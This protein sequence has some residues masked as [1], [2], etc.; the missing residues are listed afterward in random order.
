VAAP[1]TDLLRKKV[2]WKWGELQEKAFQE[3]K[4]RGLKYPV[5]IPPDFS[6][7]MILHTDA[8][9]VGIGATLSNG[10]EDGTMRMIAYRSKKLTAAEKN[11]PVHEKDASIWGHL[12]RVETLFIGILRNGVHRQFSID[13]PTKEQEAIT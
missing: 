5:L 1:L 9:D 4:L 2:A 3:L 6:K 13:A 11:Y 12:G 8:S 7:P 10:Y